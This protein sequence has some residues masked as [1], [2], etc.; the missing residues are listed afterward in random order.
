MVKMYLNIVLL[1]CCQELLLVDNYSL[2]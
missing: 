1:L 2:Y